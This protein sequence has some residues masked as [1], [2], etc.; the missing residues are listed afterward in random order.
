MDC[1]NNQPGVWTRRPQVQPPY[2]NTNFGC[3]SVTLYPQMPSETSRPDRNYSNV[4]PASSLRRR[5]RSGQTSCMTQPKDDFSN[6]PIGMGYVPWQRWGQVYSLKQGFDR[7]TIFP[8][9][10][11]PFTMGRCPK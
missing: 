6:M 11:F 10:D 7:G 3:P 8:E 9:L 2:G 1:S 5:E 4:M